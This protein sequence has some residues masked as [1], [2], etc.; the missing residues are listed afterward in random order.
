MLCVTCAGGCVAQIPYAV[1][2][3]EDPDGLA[4][5]A[6]QLVVTLD[7]SAARILTLGTHQFPVSFELETANAR[8]ATVSVE[9]SDASGTALA[10]GVAS[11]KIAT[12]NKTTTTVVL[13]KACDTDAVCSDNNLCNGIEVCDSGRCVAGASLTFDDG[14]PCT[15]DACDEASGITHV[16]ANDLTA[17]S[18]SA[19]AVG[20]CFSGTCTQNVCGDRFVGSPEQCDD[21]ANGNLCDGCDDSCRIIA[22]YS[23]GDSYIC[24][25][26][27]CDNG[28][29]NSDASC[30]GCCRSN[31]QLQ[32]C[33]DGIVDPGETCDDGNTVAFDGCTNCQPSE[34]RLYLASNTQI[35]CDVTGNRLYRNAHFGV[36]LACYSSSDGSLQVAFT[37]TPQGTYDGSASGIVANAFD[38]TAE[39]YALAPCAG[40]PSLALCAQKLDASPTPVGSPVQLSATGGYVSAIMTPDDVL[41][42]LIGDD[43]QPGAP[44]LSNA[45]LDATL[46]PFRQHRFAVSARERDRR[47][48][49]AFQSDEHISRECLRNRDRWCHWVC[50][51]ERDSKLSL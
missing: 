47:V 39:S 29:A 32:H 44:G 14:N 13:S 19:I 16:P 17:C 7:G 40:S 42:S 48:F 1:V 20:A 26:E 41:V 27:A 34:R 35:T 38:S 36:G 10:R 30:A 50:N 25:G 45:E 11:P 15:I 28:P 9:A 5:N 2:S 46:R 24:N 37:Q 4:T 33:G 21:G 3:V 43:Q 23:C 49:G 31:C 18:T 22:T 12:G 51:R 6:V 8:T